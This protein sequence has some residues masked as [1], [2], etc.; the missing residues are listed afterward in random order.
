MTGIR[1]L[2]APEFKL[3]GVDGRSHSLAD[4]SD[5]R[6]L[7]MV[8]TCNHC[9]YAQAWEGR[10]NAIA[11]EYVDRGVRLVAIN[12]NDAST[13]P[14]DSFAEM[15]KR[16]KTQDLSFD[17]LHDESQQLARTLG[18]ERTPE[19]FVFD[20]ERRLVYHGAVDDN[21]DETASRSH[22]LRDA[23]EAIL[24]GQRPA[25]TDTP[26]VGCTVKWRT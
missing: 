7:V 6:A 13:H 25:V 23:L 14:E 18:A 16:A 21:R 17:Y 19:V 22:Y 15:V 2:A 9:P 26:A 3:P 1:V 10:V 12:S 4:Y 11:R 8:Q 5:A 20:D 24:G